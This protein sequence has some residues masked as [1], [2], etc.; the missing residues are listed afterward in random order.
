MHNFPREIPDNFIVWTYRMVM[1]LGN[2]R[3]IDIFH[4]EQVCEEKGE[5]AAGISASKIIAI[6]ASPTEHPKNIS[7]TN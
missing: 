7:L 6:I 3:G 4:N 1:W 2:L 5:A